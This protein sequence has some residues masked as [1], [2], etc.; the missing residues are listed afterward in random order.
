MLSIFHFFAVLAWFAYFNAE[1]MAANVNTTSIPFRIMALGA[2][3]SFGIGSTTGDSYRKDLQDLLVANGD[4]VEFVG[5]KKNGNFSNNAVEAV[6]GFVIAQ[7][8]AA[9][10]ASVSL[11]PIFRL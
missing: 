7:I 10:N 4:T 5:S 8:A 6:P 9:A 3:V 1:T 11:E 2:S